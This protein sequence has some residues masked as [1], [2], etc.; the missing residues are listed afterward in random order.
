MILPSLPL[1][2]AI[3]VAVAEEDKEAPMGPWLNVVFY[4]AYYYYY[5]SFRCLRLYH[6]G[7]K[8]EFL[9]CEP[10]FATAISN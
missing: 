2:A 5:S 6:Y 4:L 7:Q 10:R 8:V 9:I 3:V 1:A